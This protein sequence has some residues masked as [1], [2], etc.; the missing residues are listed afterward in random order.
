MYSAAG[1]GVA[2]DKLHIVAV[3]GDGQVVGAGTRLSALVLRVMDPNG[4]SIAG[5]TVQVHQAV[6]G[7]Q[8]ACPATG[9]CPVASVYGTAN[10]A[11]VSDDDGLITIDPLQYSGAAAVTNIVAAT[12]ISGYLA[13]S[14][15]KQP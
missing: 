3:S 5:A 8:P 2:Q 15:T 14:L 7:W 6:S 1:G 11:L 12:G 4:H 9:R 10:T 13:I